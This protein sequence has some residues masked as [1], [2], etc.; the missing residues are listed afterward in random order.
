MKRLPLEPL[1]RLLLCVLGLA[2]A[3]RLPAQTEEIFKTRPPKHAE[4]QRQARKAYEASL[5][6]FGKDTNLLVLPGVI[7][8][9]RRQRV[10][11]TV[12]STRLARGAPCEFAVV[13]EDSE[14]A[15]EALLIAFAKPSAIQRALQF[16]GKRPGQPANPEA[17]Q[18][19]SRGECFAL[20]VVAGSNP[21]VRL[22]SLFLD[23]RTDEPL[24]QEGFRFIGS[25]MVPS[26]RDSAETV[27]AADVAQPMSV[28]SLFNFAGSVFE[29]PH[30]ASQGDVYQNTVIN[31]GNQLTEEGLLTLVIEPLSQEKAKGVRELVLRVERNPA[32][33]TRP[34]A[35][36]ERIGG[37]SFQLQDG[38]VVLNATPSLSSALES[39]AAL[40]RKKLEC[41]LTV[42]FGDDV[43]L[44]SAQALAKLLVIM[45][46]ERGVRINPPPPK[47]LNYRAFLPDRGL[48]DR[49]QRPAHP[50]ELALSETN[51]TLSGTLLRVDSLWPG[52]ATTPTLQ[53]VEFPVASPRELQ[54]KMESESK[55]AGEA[56]SFSRSPA[57]MVFAPASLK[58]GALMKFLE[59]V[60]PNRRIVYLFLN[61]PLPPMPAKKE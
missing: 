47:Q 36:L 24:P 14:H 22:E 5:V 45:D 52:G 13:A 57:L 58:Y 49:E 29:V 21:P 46:N 39:L 4:N 6:Q 23:K 56:R 61:E 53:A 16:I 44:A 33:A 17:Q 43:D 25:V 40:D 18:F 20:S 59:P 28:V 50:W 1:P 26:A 15:Y 7:A 34:L 8:D 9:Q 12:E 35:G 32:M 11:V 38:P 30:L 27:Y 31:P 60:L 41:F 19:W 10:E 54:I 55:S 51:G 2:F 3:S 48:L 37:L 42:S